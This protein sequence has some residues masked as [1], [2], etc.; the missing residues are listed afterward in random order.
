MSSYLRKVRTACGAVA[1]QIAVKG[2]RRDKVLAHLVSAHNDAEIAA[3]VEVGR[4]RLHPG[5]QTLDLF[6]APTTS[7]TGAIVTG[8][9]S[10]LLLEVLEHAWH[11]LGLEAPAG[12][13]E[14]FK[15][16]VMARL[17]E[18]TSKEQV[19]QVLAKKRL[20]SQCSLRDCEL[21][22]IMIDIHRD[23]Y[24]V[25]GVR[26]MWHTMKRAGRDIGRDQVACLMHTA[27]LR[28]VVRGRKPI[29]T[30]PAK[31]PDVRPDLVLRNF[32]APGPNRGCGLLIL[33][34]CAPSLGSC[35]PH[36][37]QTCTPGR[38]LVGQPRLASPPKPFPWKP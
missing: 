19:P 21:I 31:T 4:Q 12:G 11:A 23:N 28:S 29:T 8:Q 16:M 26:K 5:Q 17:V 14:G 30:R 3:L 33:P 7:S 20:P 32:R 1:V 18:P 2:G 27:G 36:L 37:S 6:P 38:S 24:S 10:T 34:M 15:Q 22:P 35:T 13:D 25:Y 9:R